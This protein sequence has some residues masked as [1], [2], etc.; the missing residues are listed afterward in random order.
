[1]ASFY[2]ASAS[3]APLAA[4]RAPLDRHPRYKL[5]L[6]SLN[7][8]YGGL[9]LSAAPTSAAARGS[10]RPPSPTPLRVPSASASS[11]SGTSGADRGAS[12][13]R[14]ALTIFGSSKSA[15][16]AAAA[17]AA[18][19][20]AAEGK[21]SVSAAAQGVPF[22]LRLAVL[23]GGFAFEAYSTPTG[24]DKLS[25]VDGR[26]CSA[27]FTSTPFALELFQGQL[28]VR[29]ITAMGNV[30]ALHAELALVT[31]A[32]KPATWNGIA[33]TTVKAQ[34]PKNPSWPEQLQLLV[35]RAAASDTL[36]Q[37]T[38]HS[39]DD[40]DDH[41]DD[42]NCVVGTATIALTDLIKD[43]RIRDVV[44]KVTRDG[45]PT[46]NVSMEVD[47]ASFSGP[48][49]SFEPLPIL[50]RLL[51]TPL[52]TSAF[53]PSAALS[54]GSTVKNKATAAATATAA[55]A[56][57]PS[58]A[59]PAAA[60]AAAAGQVSAVKTG[61]DAKAEAEA[62]AYGLSLA[63]QRA[64]EALFATGAN[65]VTLAAWENLSRAAAGGQPE[66]FKSA[67]ESV[68]FLSS[69]ESDTQ[70]GVWRDKDPRRKRV[71]VSFRGTEVVNAAMLKDGQAGQKIKDAL[72]DLRLHKENFDSDLTEEDNKMDIKV[73]DGFLGGYKS[74]KPRLLLLL[75]AIL[76]SSTEK[77]HI[78]VTG[79]SLG[80][81]LSTLFTYD[82]AQSDLKKQHGFTLSLYNFGSPRVGNHAFAARFNQL[83]G[84]SWRIANDHDIVPRVPYVF[85]KHVATGVVLRPDSQK[86]DKDALLK[87]RLDTITTVSFLSEQPKLL[88]DGAGASKHSQP[89]YFLSLLKQ[90]RFNL[91]RK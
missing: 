34:D 7:S 11:S 38:L 90:V 19:T 24:S 71:V 74:V 77:Y 73:H 17:A 48:S 39:T 25:D 3:L 50:Q 49:D 12:V 2:A 85:Y 70:V 91:N 51:T 58:A 42:H 36:L 62:A 89:A 59:A 33:H 8:S 23:L 6:S 15:A 78:M 46:G 87:K 66:F 20:A 43:T 31:S 45:K 28:S 18:A 21:G 57:T 76:A 68:C 52:P 64:V 37:I 55:A 35:P 41:A 4:L 63:D 30:K 14:D 44:A 26:Q 61:E 80:G 65:N 22:D 79:H 47:Y 60:A 83:V 10:R 9:R 82:L 72:T 53:Q 84:D 56:A 81:A 13:L 69:G 5:S 88:F 67:F 40:S 29:A 27:L 75:K 86:L 32:G 54:R 16:T 1:M